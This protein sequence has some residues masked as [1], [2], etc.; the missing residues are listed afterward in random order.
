MT[1]WCQRLFIWLGTI[2]ENEE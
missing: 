1:C 2:R